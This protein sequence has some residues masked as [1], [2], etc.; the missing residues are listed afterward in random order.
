MFIRSGKSRVG[1]DVP[2]ERPQMAARHYTRPKLLNHNGMQ[3][4]EWRKSGVELN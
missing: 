4:L 2:F 1:E 3:I